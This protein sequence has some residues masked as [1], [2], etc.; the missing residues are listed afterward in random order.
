[1]IRKRE[2]YFIVCYDISNAKRWRKVF[3]TLEGYGE[4]LQLSVFQ[5]RMSAAKKQK[6]MADLEDII[7]EKEDHILF[8]DMGNPDKINEK[9]KSLGKAFYPIERKPL[10]F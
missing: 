5:I 7:N 9:V 10:V 6:L 3:Q 2:R 8:V 4:W 1:M